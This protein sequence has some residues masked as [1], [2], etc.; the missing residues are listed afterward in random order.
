MAREVGEVWERGQLIVRPPDSHQWWVS[1]AQ[2]PTILPLDDGL[3]RVYFAARDEGPVSR[4]MCVDLDPGDSLRVVCL[5][6]DP[7][8]VPGRAGRF[9]CHGVGPASAL[10]IGGKIYL[11]YTGI[12]ERKDVPYALAIGAAVSDDGLSFE[13]L[14]DG[15]VFAIGPH[16]PYFASTP[17]VR[18]HRDGYEMWYS[19]GLGWSDAPCGGRVEPLYNIRRTTSSDGLIWSLGSEHVLGGGGEHDGGIV[20]PWLL[21]RPNA[22]S[23]WYCSRG[24]H[25]FRAGGVHAYRIWHGKIGDDGRTIQD[26]APIR[27]APQE[28]DSAWDRD[29][30][31]YPC[32]GVSGED[33]VM[34]YNGNGFG[35]DGFGY[36]RLRGGARSLQQTGEKTL[37][38]QQAG[39]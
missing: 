11:F 8:L 1:H 20:R 23:I 29:M 16:D 30:Q 34:L 21:E 24:A 9:D 33:L 32:V 10:R 4:I 31:A 39:E 13:Q 25:G 22:T 27:F 18:R 6:E 2:A 7:V 26:R 14:S 28:A 36:A 3:W 38:A 37:R 12:V 35:R 19:S 17:F 15:P 5:H